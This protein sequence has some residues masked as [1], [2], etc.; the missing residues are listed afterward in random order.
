M[1]EIVTGKAEIL[2][3]SFHI[4]AEPPMLLAERLSAFATFPYGLHSTSTGGRLRFHGRAPCYH[5][6]PKAKTTGIAIPAY[7]TSVFAC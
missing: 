4:H 2:F 7:V 5:F 1:P 6:W 3:L